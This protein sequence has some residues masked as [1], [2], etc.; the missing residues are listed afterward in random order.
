MSVLCARTGSLVRIPSLYLAHGSLNTQASV[1]SCPP[2]FK[3]K[4]QFK[5]AIKFFTISK[6]LFKNLNFGKCS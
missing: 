1:A 3:F 5:T 6:H 4:I 2:V